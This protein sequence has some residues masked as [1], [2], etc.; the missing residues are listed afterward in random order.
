[1]SVPSVSICGIGSLAQKPTA[2]KDTAIPGG[3][4]ALLSLFIE[5]AKGDTVWLDKARTVGFRGICE[6]VW[7]LH[8]GG[9]QVCEKWLK[10]RKGRTLSQKEIVHYQEIIV[11]LTETIQYMKEI[12]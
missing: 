7:N 12:D 5:R 3:S 2:P 11:A 8:I 6:P 10:D 9:Y 1:M 4:V